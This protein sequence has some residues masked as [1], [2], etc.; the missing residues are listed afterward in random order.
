ME[1]HVKIVNNKIAEFKNYFQQVRKLKFEQRPDYDYFSTQ[2]RDLF[3][4][5]KYE[6][7]AIFEWTLKHV[8]SFIVIAFYRKKIQ[9]IRGL[10][11]R[12]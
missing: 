6:A 2:F 9:F 11:L 4:R 1:F 7:S 5:K 10:T 12:K 8:N 3:Y